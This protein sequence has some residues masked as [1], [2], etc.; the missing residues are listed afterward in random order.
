[1]S[2]GANSE[3]RQRPSADALVEETA[4]HLRLALGEMAL[5]LRPFPAFMNMVSLQAVELEPGPA[6]PGDQGCVVVLP[7]GEICK[8]E[9]KIAP[10]TE[11]SEEIDS[12]DELSELELA[13]EDYITYASAAIRLLYLE[14]RRRGQ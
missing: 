13:P 8:L 14:L 1:M 4:A 12:V 10:A 3:D 9:L 6:T 11:G 2:T 7:E 5:R